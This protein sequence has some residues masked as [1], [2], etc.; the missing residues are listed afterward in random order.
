M[1][2]YLKMTKVSG[3]MEKLGPNCRIDDREVFLRLNRACQR[4]VVSR[5]TM[6]DIPSAAATRAHWNQIRKTAV[7][8]DCLLNQKRLVDGRPNGLTG[9]AIGLVTQDTPT[10]N[11]YDLQEFRSSLGILVKTADLIDVGVSAGAYRDKICGQRGGAL[12][13]RLLLDLACIF[14]DASGKKA[15]ITFDP[16]METHSG[17]FLGFVKLV[18]D[19]LGLEEN[20]KSIARRLGKVPRPSGGRPSPRTGETKYS[21]TGFIR[22]WP[23]L[24]C[25]PKHNKE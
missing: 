18:F 21:Y 24:M 15:T 10:F 4:F 2:H 19:E 20:D 17:A 8:L 23:G 1:M 16:V 9:Y 3:L 22:A 13:D 6:K 11:D 12:I 14:T 5:V 7:A 25:E